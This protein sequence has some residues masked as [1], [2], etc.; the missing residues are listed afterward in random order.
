M[1]HSDIL[2]ALDARRDILTE[3]Y[4]ALQ[5]IDRRRD[6]LE[7]DPDLVAEL[8]IVAAEIHKTSAAIRDILKP[9]PAWKRL[10]FAL[11]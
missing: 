10:L 9:L 4:I 6:S 8:R 7:S 2:A 1:T 5:S 3:R 11:V